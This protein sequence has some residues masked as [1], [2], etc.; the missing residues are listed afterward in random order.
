MLVKLPRIAQAE[1]NVLLTGETGT[2]KELCARAIHH[3]SARRPAPFIAVDSG[4]LPEGLLESELFGHTAGAFTDARAEH[5]GLAALAEGGVLFLDEVD[6]LSPRLQS[7]LLRFLEERT[8]KPLGS[9]RFRR[10]DVRMIAATNRNL[11]ALVRTGAF[12]SDLYFRMNVLHLRLPPLRE[13]PADIPVLAEHFLQIQPPGRGQPRS[14]APS[15]LRKLTLH[16]WPGNVRELLN[17]VQ[18]AVVFAD[19]P[20]IRAQD[21]DLTLPVDVGEAPGAGFRQ[22][23][24]DALARFERA[25]VENLLRKH[26]GNITR[27]AREARKDRRAFGRLVKRL[28]VVT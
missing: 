17:V 4:A 28:G 26:N 7:K 5:R 27:A 25:F 15:A 9:E 16:H 19:G 11:E 10:A 20:V 18:R 2:G 22:A 21:I 24:A 23:R 14:L 8:Y 6:A 12:R 13:R 3:L 1:G